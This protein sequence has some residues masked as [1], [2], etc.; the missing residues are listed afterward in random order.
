MEQQHMVEIG[1]AVILLLAL[2]GCDR[3]GNG[4]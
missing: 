2:F 1:A 4:S 3:R